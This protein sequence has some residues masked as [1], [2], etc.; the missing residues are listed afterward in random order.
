MKRGDIVTISHDAPGHNFASGVK[1]RS[2]TL[3]GPGEYEIGGVFVTGFG[4]PV[5][6]LV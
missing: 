6:P 4:F 5:V 1:G 3:T 2:H